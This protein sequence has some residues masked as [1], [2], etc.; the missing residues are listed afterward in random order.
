MM[1]IAYM[2]VLGLSGCLVTVFMSN[3]MIVYMVLSPEKYE[4]Y[5]KAFGREATMG[6][7]F[8]Y[9]YSIV[10]TGLMTVNRVVIVTSPLSGHFSTQRIFIYSGIL[11]VL[12]FITLIIP[13][14]SD[15]SITFSLNRLSFISACAPNKHWITAFQNTY[16]IVIPLSCMVINMGIVFHVRFKRQKTY[17][18]IKNWYYN[19]RSQVQPITLSNTSTSSTSISSQ[20]KNKKDFTMM[21]QTFSVAIFLSIYELGALITRIFPNA[22]QWFPEGFRDG[23]F[24]FRMESIALMNYF[25]YYLHTPLSRRMI[26]RFLRL[27]VPSD[28]PITLATVNQPKKVTSSPTVLI[29]N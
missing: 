23:Y 7:T 14:F 8:S 18:R 2:T 6:S 19:F 1:P 25:I 20:Q 4:E 28:V 16:A 26:R 10:I 21:R 9:L 17:E 12:V 22:Y 11:A 15:C 13:Y 3:N 29:I 5:L 24:Y 27:K